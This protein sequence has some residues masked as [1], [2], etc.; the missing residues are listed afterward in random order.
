MI[1]CAPVLDPDLIKPCVARFGKRLNKIQRAAIGFFPI[2]ESDVANLNCRNAFISIFRLDGMAFERGD[3]NGN[4]EGRSRRIRRTIRSRQ[5][6]NVRIV[7]Q[8]FELFGRDGGNKQIW[9]VGRP[10]SQRQNV[11]VV[12]IDNHDGAA[13]RFCFQRLFSQLL[14]TQVKRG[15][16]VVTGLRRSDQFLGSL[17][18][19]FIEGEFVFAMLACEHLVERLL[20][21]LASLGF[22][23]RVSWLSTMP[24]GFRPVF[25]V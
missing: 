12:W 2:V 14:K 8:E 4:L 11:A 17:P 18:T 3:S 6:R 19:I 22:G 23:Q 25:P 24:S 13:F 21:S 1:G 10:G 16:H 5:K 7:L 20:E 15:D 9:I